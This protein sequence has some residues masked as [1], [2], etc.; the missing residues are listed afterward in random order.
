MEPFL[1]QI[2]YPVI[3]MSRNYTT[4]TIK[5]TQKCHTCPKNETESKFWIPINFAISSSLNFSSTFATH[6]LTPNDNELIIE[7]IQPDD[8]LIFNIQSS[9]IFNL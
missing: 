3:D 7:G 5:L 9:G 6:W 4:G 2:G 1:S 8:W